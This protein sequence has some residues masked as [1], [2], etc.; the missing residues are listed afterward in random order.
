VNARTEASRPTLDVNG[1]ELVE[2]ESRLEDF[3]EDPKGSPSARP[4]R[5][6]E[7]RSLVFFRDAR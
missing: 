3:F 5:S 6:I 7:V 2:H 1:F 4:R